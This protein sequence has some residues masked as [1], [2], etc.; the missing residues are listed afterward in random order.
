M[1]PNVDFEELDRLT[2][3]VM[4]TGTCMF[5]SHLMFLPDGR[6]SE[7]GHARLLLNEVNPEQSAHICSMGC[8]VGQL[9]LM[10][11]SMRS[12]LRFTL[13]NLS[14]T[15]LDLCPI[16]PSFIHVYADAHDSHLPSNHYDIVLFHTSLV[17]MDR[18]AALQEAY[19][20]LKPGG[21]LVLWEMIRICGN[22]KDWNEL[23]DGDVPYVS[24]LDDAVYC[25]GFNF[26]KISYPPSS[27]ER[28]INMLPDAMHQM[29]SEVCCV[30]MTAYKPED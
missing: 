13:V 1:K 11:H 2:P 30:L 3:E 6:A 7:A 20:I 18:E 21:R 10:W 24:E 28:F 16:G 12:D 8:G 15:Q 14:R 5:T 17:Q 4:A 9:E 22:N 23:L 25:A 29:V 27:A 19:R 26:N